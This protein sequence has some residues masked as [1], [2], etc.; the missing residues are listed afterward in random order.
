[1][2][3][4]RTHSAIA[5]IKG[6][7]T[8]NMASFFV[9]VYEELDARLERQLGECSGQVSTPCLLKDEIHTDSPTKIG[10]LGV[11]IGLV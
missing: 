8:K 2:V 3:G 10:L 9:G 6:D 1:M 4:D 11:H 7:M 5:F